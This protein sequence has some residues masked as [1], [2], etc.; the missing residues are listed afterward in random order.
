VI[1]QFFFDAGLDALG[2]PTLVSSR[3]AVPLSVWLAMGILL[4][5]IFFWN[6]MIFCGP[7]VDFIM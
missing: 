5:S 6:I 4:S 2:L 3:M 1:G 7:V